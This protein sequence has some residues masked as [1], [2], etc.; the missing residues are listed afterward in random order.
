MNE[1]VTTTGRGCVLLG[2]MT[3]SGDPVR[4][5]FISLKMIILLLIELKECILSPLSQFYI[6]LDIPDRPF[7]DIKLSSFI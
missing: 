1:I 4:L 5:V 3:V 2:S 6:Y 7:S